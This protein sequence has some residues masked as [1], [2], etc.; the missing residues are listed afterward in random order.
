M[1]KENLISSFQPFPS[2]PNGFK[3]GMRLEGVDPKHQSLICVLS[4]AEVQGYRLRLHF[5]GYS[6]CYDFWL[7]ADSPFIFPVGFAEKNG[8]TL[9]PPKSKS[10][11]SFSYSNNIF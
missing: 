6:E 7:N 1:L 4:V 10:L 9:Q 2:S 3:L 8:K 11:C 5:D